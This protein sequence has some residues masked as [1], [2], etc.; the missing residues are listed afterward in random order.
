MPTTVLLFLKSPVPGTVKTRLA[1]HIGAERATE[2]Y[3]SMVQ[4][5]IGRLPL[6][7]TR[8]IHFSPPSD[9]ELMRNWLGE[10]E[11]Y[12]PQVEGDLGQRLATGFSGAFHRGAD[13]ACAIG[14]DCPEL[15]EAHFRETEATLRSASAD[16]VFGPAEDGGYT[17]VAL[18][19][20]QPTLFQ[21]IPW[22]SPKTLQS[23]L[24]AARANGLRV[25]LLPTLSD[26]D[27]YEDY[28]R[29]HGKKG[30]GPVE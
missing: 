30:S 15:A 9:L 22:S 10:G 4:S 26:L 27:T 20:S 11:D 6:N 28:Q 21:G 2:L 16:V 3:R 5:Q 7:W 23:S 19:R 18:C 29:F 24:S 1:A 17:L 14:G 12:H 13:L 8:E 25:H